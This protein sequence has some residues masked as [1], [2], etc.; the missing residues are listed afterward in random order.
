LQKKGL[1][2]NRLVLAGA[3]WL[4]GEARNPLICNHVSTG[5]GGGEADF[6]NV[7]DLPAPA[8]AGRKIAI[9]IAG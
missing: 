5:R 7:I 8:G 2:Q 3:R 9:G 1:A 6:L 4:I